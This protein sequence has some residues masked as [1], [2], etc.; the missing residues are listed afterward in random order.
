MGQSAATKAGARA[1][2]VQESVDRLPESLLSSSPGFVFR[3]GL[4]Y[5]LGL[6]A[7]LSQRQGSGPGFPG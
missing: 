2:P 7:S 5:R 1:N 6:S 3:L 4:C